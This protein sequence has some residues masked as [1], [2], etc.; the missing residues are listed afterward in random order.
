MLWADFEPGFA[1]IPGGGLDWRELIFRL[2]RLWNVAWHVAR[3][4]GTIACVT[5]YVIS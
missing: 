3:D 4:L 1:R 5:N 2:P